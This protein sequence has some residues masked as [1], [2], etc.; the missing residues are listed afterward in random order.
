MKPGEKA[1]EMELRGPTS[2]STGYPRSL[3]NE[4]IFSIDGHALALATGRGMNI[5]VIR[6]GPFEALKMLL[7][8]FENTI[9]EPV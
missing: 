2:R 9:L 6:A 7:K 3:G 4:V 1:H 5:A 8:A